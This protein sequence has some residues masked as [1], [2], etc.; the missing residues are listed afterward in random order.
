MD[1]LKNKIKSTRN[2]WRETELFGFRAMGGV[3]TLSRA[4]VPAGA[5]VLF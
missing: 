5:T 1:N 2:I 4:E 3:V